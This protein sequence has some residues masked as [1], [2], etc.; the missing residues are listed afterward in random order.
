MAQPL[1]KT[2]SE[3][4]L[5]VTL[6]LILALTLTNPNPNHNSNLNTMPI[7][8]GQLSLRASEWR[9]F[10]TGQLSYTWKK[11]P[12]TGD[13][14]IHLYVLVRM[15]EKNF[16]PDRPPVQSCSLVQYDLSHHP[17]KAILFPRVV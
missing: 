9:H 11:W 16:T 4:A 17:Y 14:D 12:L 8:F 10:D 3:S 5:N 6:T 2:Q 1:K 13:G 7:R 15:S